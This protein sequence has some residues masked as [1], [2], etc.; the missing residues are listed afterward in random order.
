MRPSPF[1]VDR[2]QVASGT[3]EFRAGESK[4]AALIGRYDVESLP[5]EIYVPG[6]SAHVTLVPEKRSKTDWLLG[7]ESNTVDFAKL[8]CS[9]MVELT[10][11]GVIT[12]GSGGEN[13]SAKSDCRWLITAPP[14]KAIEFTFS[15]LHIEPD[16]DKIFFFDGSHTNG[17]IMAIISGGEV[18]PVFTTWRNQVL[19][20]FVTNENVQGA[21][22]RASYRFVDR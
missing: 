4:S 5:E 7:F 20:W 17:D 8:Y 22:W 19:V 2:K 3:L 13:Y 21:G 11:E 16:V 10:E 18:P 12:D 14:G 6:P 9:G 15:E 1:V